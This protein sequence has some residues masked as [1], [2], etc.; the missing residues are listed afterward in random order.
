[1]SL[2]TITDTLDSKLRNLRS[3]SESN[4]EN[5]SNRDFP[6]NRRHTLGQPLH[7]HSENIPYADESPERLFH[8]FCNPLDAA[9]L[10][11]HLSRSCTATNTIGSSVDDDEKLSSKPSSKPLPPSLLKAA[12]HKLQHSATVPIHQGSSTAP[13]SG[14]ATPTG[15][16]PTGSG[17]G[18]AIPTR[19]SSSSVTTL[20]KGMHPPRFG[21]NYV[22][23]ERGNA[24]AAGER[25]A[26]AAGGA[27]S[28]GGGG[29]A[30]EDDSEGSTTSDPKEKLMLGERPSPS[31]F[32]ERYNKKRR[33]HRLFRSASFNCRNYSTRH[34]TSAPGGSS[35][36]AIAVGVACC[37]ALS[38]TATGTG[39]GTGTGL[40]KD[41]KTD[42]NLTKKRQIQNK[43]NR[44]IK[45]RHTVGGPHDYSASNGSCSHAHSHAHG[46]GGHDLAAINYNH[47][48]RHHQQQLLKLNTV[49]ST[50]SSGA[51][52]ALE[53]ELRRQRPRPQPQRRQLWCCDAWLRAELRQDRVRCRV[54]AAATT[55]TRR[56][57]MA[58]MGI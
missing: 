41:E 52:S 12:A 25:V 6:K 16:T 7:M 58:A 37:Q 49:S 23:Y 56:R 3:G 51:G 54:Q 38:A 50:S 14:A 5:G 31:F 40:T 46:H 44:S 22:S 42:M 24:G 55:I 8:Q 43:Q 4:D 36:A 30:S 9:P 53:L 11:L 35:A 18:G 17:G 29:A 13:T 19:S 27:P 20:T 10:S 39:S 26:A 47:H 57:A 2:T 34:M 28:G 32:L 1:M 21:N 48:N 15:S 45:R 33:D